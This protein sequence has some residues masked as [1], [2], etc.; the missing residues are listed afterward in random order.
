MLLNLIFKE[1]LYW[2]FFKEFLKTLTKDLISLICVKPD[3]QVMEITHEKIEPKNFKLM[4]IFLL[5]T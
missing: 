5:C 4:K 2:K 1:F 3:V